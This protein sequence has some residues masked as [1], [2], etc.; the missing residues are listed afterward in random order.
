MERD[1][2]ECIS[3]QKDKRQLGTNSI[4]YQGQIKHS[5]TDC[6]QWWRTGYV[7]EG[8][9]LVIAYFKN[10]LYTVSQSLLTEN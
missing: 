4:I 8:S 5:Q 6:I 9:A 3:R 2:T 7:N 10:I 1:L